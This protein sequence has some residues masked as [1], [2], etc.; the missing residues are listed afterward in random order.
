MEAALYRLMPM[1]AQ[2]V[3]GS[4]SAA[5]GD[6][7]LLSELISKQPTAEL[8]S[9]RA[10]NE[11]AALD[12]NAAEADWKKYMQAAADRTPGTDR[13]WPISIIGGCARRTRSRLSK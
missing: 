2:K 3:L 13:R 7:P 5:R 1:P 10:L 6:V 12:F 11:E 9:L 4:A 8:Y